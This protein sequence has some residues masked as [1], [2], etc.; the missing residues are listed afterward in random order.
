MKIEPLKNPKIGG[1]VASSTLR[2]K[3]SSKKH[4]LLDIYSR[5]KIIHMEEK[6]LETYSGAKRTKRMRTITKIH[7]EPDETS[8][9]TH[10]IRVFWI[11]E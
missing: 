2:K 10:I 7:L 6:S 11:H 5:W 4:G 1:K 8:A 9:E 3:M